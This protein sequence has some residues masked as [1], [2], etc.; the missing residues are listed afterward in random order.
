M[1][2]ILTINNLTKIYKGKEA[3]QNISFAIKKGEVIGLVGPNTPDCWERI[4]INI[5]LPQ[6]LMLNVF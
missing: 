4:T 6:L 1:T 5:T 2:G 3:I